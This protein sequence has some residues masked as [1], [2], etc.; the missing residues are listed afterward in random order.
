MSERSTL[1]EVRPKVRPS[2]IPLEAA[3]PAS[4]RVPAAASIRAVAR[5][6]TLIGR[7]GLNRIGAD[8]AAVLPRR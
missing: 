3:A 6:E 5:G 7:G 1:A 8:V 4:E 2:V